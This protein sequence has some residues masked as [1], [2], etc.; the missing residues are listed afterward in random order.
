MRSTRSKW[1]ST[2]GRSAGVISLIVPTNSS[3]SLMA[4]WETR[5]SRLPLTKSTGRPIATKPRLLLGARSGS[6][7]KFS[8]KHK[9]MSRYSSASSS[10]ER[11][12]AALYSISGAT[13]FR[14]TLE[15][16]RPS[17]AIGIQTRRSVSSSTG[18]RMHTRCIFVGRGVRLT[19]ASQI[20]SC[21]FLIETI[22][23]W[24][25]I[26]HTAAALTCRRFCMPRSNT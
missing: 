9:V 13:M 7:A 6:K 26:N 21:L 12:S 24:H 20:N 11:L 25:S 3:S 23:L 18:K 2:T 16:A 4:Y 19:Y 5:T 10:G 8:T 15:T 17:D 22:S 14:T 1:L